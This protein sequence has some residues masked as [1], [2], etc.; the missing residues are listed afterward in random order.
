MINMLSR[1]VS[2]ALGSDDRIDCLD[3][4][5][6]H[7]LQGAELRA[8]LARLGEVHDVPLGAN[9]N[10]VA[11]LL[12]LAEVK[13]F[14]GVE[15]LTEVFARVE[16]LRQESGEK[17]GF[18]ADVDLDQQRALLAAIVS[19]EP[20][21]KDVFGFYNLRGSR[22][23]YKVLSVQGFCNRTGIYWVWTGEKHVPNQAEEA[24]PQPEILTLNNIGEISNSHFVC[25]RVDNDLW[26]DDHPAGHD[27]DGGVVLAG[28][29]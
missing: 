13:T 21:L 28:R 14:L 17:N 10:S 4:A 12:K 15:N 11:V 6:T 3:A 26:D 22:K 2:L 8:L 5:N 20:G 7:R 19:Q 9:K 24:Y 23:L 27:D 25:R 1:I 16:G 29:N 18:I